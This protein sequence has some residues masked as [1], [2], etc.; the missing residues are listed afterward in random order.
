VNYG[1]VAV[2]DS[3]QES[4][5]SAYAD[6]TYTGT[7]EGFRGGVTKI[8]VTVKNG[9]ITNIQDISNEDDP[10][11]FNRAYNTVVNSILSAQSA[12]VDAVSGATYSSRGI[13]EAVANA[14]ENA[15]EGTIRKV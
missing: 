1:N 4:N 8:S 3:A 2:A 15:D 10:P 14:L 7:G 9:I 12:D 11:Y 5:N 6:G 13:M